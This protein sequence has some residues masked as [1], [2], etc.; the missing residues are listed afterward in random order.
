MEE[1]KLILQLLVSKIDKLD[2]RWNENTV[3]LSRLTETVIQH[4]QRSTNIEKIQK[5]CR[6]S[7][8][9]DIKAAEK[10]AAEVALNM[11]NI[12]NSFKTMAWVITGII[13]LLTAAF[14]LY[15][16][17]KGLPH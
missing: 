14:Q 6:E 8:D 16:A 9:A 1:S 17:Y 5:A 2:E 10:I 15:S 12:K 11:I 7:C 3:I 13:A 4:E